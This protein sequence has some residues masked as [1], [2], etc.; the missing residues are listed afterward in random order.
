MWKNYKC[1]D[2]NIVCVTAKDYKLHLNCD[3]HDSTK[4]DTREVI[5]NTPRKWI[6]ENCGELFT[7][8]KRYWS[9][10]GSKDFN[11]EYCG[12]DDCDVSFETIEMLLD[13][14]IDVFMKYFHNQRELIT[15]KKT[16]DLLGIITLNV[17]DQLNTM[18]GEEEVK[19]DEEDDVNKNICFSE[20]S[21]Q[22]TDSLTRDHKKKR[23]IFFTHPTI[24]KQK[25]EEVLS[26]AT[27]I[28]YVLEP[29]C[30]SCEFI[31]QLHSSLPNAI[32]DGVE[33]D[34]QIY[35]KVNHLNSN[36][37]SITNDDFLQFET[38]RKYDL[39]IGNPPYFVIK[40]SE[41]SKEYHPYL[42]G[43]P[44]I[45]LLFILRSLSMLSHNG[46]IA[47]VLPSNFLNCSYYNKVR[48]Y[49]YEKF[50]LLKVLDCSNEFL[51]TDQPTNII[52]IQNKL[53]IG[54]NPYVLSMNNSIIFNTLIGIERITG[55][56]KNST[57]LDQL[58]F[59]VHVGNVVWNQ[60]KDILT[61]NNNKT[62]LVYSSDFKDNKLVVTTY[63][64]P[65]KKNYIDKEG[66]T[67]PLLVVNRGYGK[68]KYCFNYCLIDIGEKPFLI[69]NHVICIKYRGEITKTDLLKL[70]KS[71]IESFKDPKTK[72]FID[73]YCTNDA[74]NTTELQHIL[75]IYV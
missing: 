50:T 34:K 11:E 75:P 19:E 58:G 25:L 41:C 3:T 47:F 51:D 16:I 12:L 10:R 37:I 74:I 27:D 44:N 69:E 39:I 55:L 14:K 6:C 30:G 65:K 22:L 8:K 7:V 45:Y 71:I 72:E 60:V 64:D 21:I 35:D 73:C 29:S 52:I 54:H 20:L 18:I 5:D 31:T 66:I 17:M 57:T 38:D 40:K 43:R 26:Y 2:C 24:V 15:I 4:I 28:K 53:T 49:I 70:Y 23:G 48:K 42:D 1:V 67:G 9:H 61:D 62:R 68:G 32:I 33:Y 13:N 36:N 63:K 46:I 56:C 59:N